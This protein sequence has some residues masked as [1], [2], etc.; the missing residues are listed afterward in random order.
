MYALSDFDN[1]EVEKENKMKAC[2]LIGSLLVDDSISQLV[3]VN[4]KNSQI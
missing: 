4:V 1:L 3:I 2:Q